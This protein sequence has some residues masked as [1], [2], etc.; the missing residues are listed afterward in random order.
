MRFMVNVQFPIVDCVPP[1]SNRQSRSCIEARVTENGATVPWI[2][3]YPIVLEQMRNM[4]MRSL[5]FN[6]GAFGLNGDATTHTIGWVGP[7]DGTLREFARR[8]V[9]RVDEPYEVNL[10]ALLV[11]AWQQIL[12]GRIWIMPKSHW[13]YELDFGS[14]DWMPALLEH[15]GIDPGLL[16]GRPTAAAIEFSPDETDAL[17]HVVQ[18]LLEMLNNSDFAA[19]FPGHRVSC[20]I[21][22]H[23]QIWWTVADQRVIE[24]LDALSPADP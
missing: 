14:R 20:T 17:R 19:A 11:R 23:K 12:P 13:A 22:S 6:S 15:V 5:Y 10:A 18:R 7:P 4:R 21:H 16:A 8:L 2:I 3:D 1:I 24:A 9:R